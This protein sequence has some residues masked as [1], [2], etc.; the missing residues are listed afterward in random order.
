MDHYRPPEQDYLAMEPAPG[1]IVIVKGDDGAEHR[2]IAEDDGDWR[3]LLKANV[4]AAYDSAWGS[5]LCVP[6]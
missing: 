4:L 2:A 3:N 6:S 1:T 5:V